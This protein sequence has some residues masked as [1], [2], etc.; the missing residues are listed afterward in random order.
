M[1]LYQAA[2]IDGSAAWR[3]CCHMC[4]SEFK[5]DSYTHTRERIHPYTQCT[6]VHRTRTAGNIALS[7]LFEYSIGQAER[8]IS[9]NWP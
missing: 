7:L 6:Y 1:T 8:D 5:A 2:M 3:R 4:C 9:P